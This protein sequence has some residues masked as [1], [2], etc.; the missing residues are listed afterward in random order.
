[1]FLNVFLFVLECLDELFALDGIGDNLQFSIYAEFGHVVEWM[2]LAPVIS[3][4]LVEDNAHKDG[5]QKDY[6]R[7][8]ANNHIGYDHDVGEVVAEDIQVEWIAGAHLLQLILVRNYRILFCSDVVPLETLKTDIFEGNPCHPVGVTEVGNSKEDG[9]ADGS[10]N[11]HAQQREDSIHKTGVLELTQ[12]QN[13]VVVSEDVVGCQKDKK[14]D[15]EY[16]FEV[17]H[18]VFQGYE[19][20][21][22]CQFVVFGFE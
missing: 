4:N 2:Y 11:V 6:Q 8:L 20:V 1:M 9:S 10:Q 7:H 17:R 13:M 16:G 15:V 12:H 22:E 18:D 21:F 19:W 14:D 3:L 5:R